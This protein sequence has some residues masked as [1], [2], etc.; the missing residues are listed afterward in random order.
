MSCFPEHYIPMDVCRLIFQN[1]PPYEKCC[2]FPTVCKLWKGL[3]VNWAK[4]KHLLL[5]TAIKNVVQASSL[6]EQVGTQQA[7]QLQIAQILCKH[8]L[9]LLPKLKAVVETVTWGDWSFFLTPYASSYD[10]YSTPFYVNW[11]PG[12]DDFS[13]TKN[14]KWKNLRDAM[15]IHFDARLWY[16]AEKEKRCIFKTLSAKVHTDFNVEQGG[17]VEWHKVDFREILA[18][19]YL[20]KELL[21]AQL[22]LYIQRLTQLNLLALN[23]LGFKLVGHRVKLA[24]KCDRRGAI[25]DHAYA[26]QTYDL[27]LIATDGGYYRSLIWD[28]PDYDESRIRICTSTDQALR[29]CVFSRLTDTLIQQWGFVGA[30]LGRQNLMDSSIFRLYS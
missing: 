17:I 9:T 14:G 24:L 21:T 6:D 10:G 12:Q 16:S 7:R 13:I 5:L 22:E 2:V 29:W 27:A 11:T 30:D 23:Q 1:I 8:G 18:E 15:C 3:S 26:G 19:V 4:E 20:A 25:V 28:T